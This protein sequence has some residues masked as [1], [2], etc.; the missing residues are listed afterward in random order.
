[1]SLPKV[2]IVGQPFNNTGGGITMTNLFK[3]WDPENWPLPAW[4]P[5]P[6]L[7]WLPAIIITGWEIR[8]ELPFSPLIIYK[9]NIYPDQ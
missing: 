4:V 9:R 2:L 7:I 1:M 5:W 6:I 3:G 8:N